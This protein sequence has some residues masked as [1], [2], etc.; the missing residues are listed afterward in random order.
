MYAA[1]NQD[2][3]VGSPWTSA[4]LLYKNPSTG[5]ISIYN[6]NNCPEI[7]CITDWMSPIATMLKKPFDR[8]S[9]LASRVSRFELLRDF[10]P[11]VC[12]ANDAVA[13]PY[14]GGP[15]FKAGRVP[16]YNTA[17][18]FLL[19]HSD[20]VN[21]VAGVTVAPWGALSSNGNLWNPPT[22][23]DMRVSRVGD[24]ARKIFIADGARYLVN[25]L[26]D[27]DISVRGSF[28][29]AFADQGGWSAFSR[30][31]VR[32]G[33]T[34]WTGKADA[35]LYAY[36]HGSQRPF[37]SGRSAFKLNVGFFDGHVETI[38]DTEAANPALWFPKGTQL[39]IL[40]ELYPDVVSKYYP[41]LTPASDPVTLP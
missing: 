21:G 15:Q 36:R 18:G 31:W 33:N 25:D 22:G 6:D 23:Y 7:I 27:V 12:P 1:E 4:R 19:A 9:S 30:S 40:G 41:G 14:T 35:R 29:G 32:A 11:F 13:T 24:A 10:G 39:K 38:G 2:A 20:G 37:D 28:G 8:G 17:L 16:S 26:P 5:A 34:N 3:I